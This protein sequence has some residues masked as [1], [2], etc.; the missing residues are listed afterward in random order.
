MS[1]AA[2]AGS[3]KDA[4]GPPRARARILRGAL[5]SLLLASVALFFLNFNLAGTATPSRRFSQDLVYAWF[6]DENW[7]YPR[8][9]FAG[10][11]GARGQPQVVVVVVNEHALAM[12]GARWPAPVQFHAQFLAELEVLRPRAI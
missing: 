2:A 3:G 12:R 4:R 10:S 6:G 5:H 7:L 8:A 11:H 9:R 1:M